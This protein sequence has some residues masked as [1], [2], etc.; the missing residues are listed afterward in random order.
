M[1][2]R[3]VSNSSWIPAP[4]QGSVNEQTYLLYPPSLQLS[5]R[6]TVP[7]AW[8]T[9]DHFLR[10]FPWAFPTFWVGCILCSQT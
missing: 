8:K 4:R 1:L 3:L 7:P 6:T 9:K 10:G 5:S 2:P